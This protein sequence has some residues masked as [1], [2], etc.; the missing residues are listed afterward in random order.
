MAIN[1]TKNLEIT[2]L[3]QNQTNKEI[4][5]N[6]GFLKID[7]LI[8]N[9]AKSLS[10]A[11][12]PSSPEEGDLYIIASSATDDW[13]GEEAKLTYYH[14]SKGW[15]ILEPNEGMTLWVNDEDKLY[16]FDGSNW[17]AS[18]V[19]ES[20]LKL[21]INTDADDT[22]KLSVKSDAVLF[23]HN[24]DDSQVKVNKDSVSDSAS[25]LFQT[26]YEGRAEFGL[27]GDDDFHIKVSSDGS[28]WNEALSIDKTSAKVTFSEGT[29]F[30]NGTFTP[31][32]KG[33]TTVGANIYD[34]QTGHYTVI[35]NRVFFDITIKLDGSTG[36]LDSTG[37]LYID[38]LP[39][40]AAVNDTACAIS[41]YAG[42]NL[43]SSRKLAAQVEESTNHVK[44]LEITSNSSSWTGVLDSEATDSL[45][46]RIAGNYM[47]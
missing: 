7:S 38:G 12:P 9:G 31:V 2:Y 42:F 18:G 5:V 35:G 46:I 47:I 36:A 20:Q 19:I 21:G 1:K 40:T 15:V 34:I 26:N 16:T 14:P 32:L 43:V 37:N 39:F 25:H 8:N 4:L 27:T 6:E 22:N 24:G 11:T 44:F 33:E 17:V 29:I 10:L 28:T 30:P 45:Q 41:K 23:D 13:S 3:S